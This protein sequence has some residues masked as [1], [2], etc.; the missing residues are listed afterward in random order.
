MSAIAAAASLRW[1]RRS[2][3]AAERAVDVANRQRLA[4]NVPNLDLTAF[5]THN[6]GPCLDLLSVDTRLDTVLLELVIDAVPGH[7]AS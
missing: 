5:L 1:S 7:P 4:S 6:D 2:A 3:I